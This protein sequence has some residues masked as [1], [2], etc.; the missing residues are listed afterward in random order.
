[1]D[2][3]VAVSLFRHG[4]TEENK[5]RAYLGWSDS[6]LCPEAKKE[7]KLAQLD[8]DLVISSDLGRCLET[9]A[10]L[11]PERPA[12]AMPELREMHFGQWE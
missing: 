12:E 6:P 11:F 5:R 8:Y 4:L 9:S 7:L 3:T 10:H 1:M 2:N